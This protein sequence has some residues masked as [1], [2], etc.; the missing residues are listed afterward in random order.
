MVDYSFS[1]EAQCPSILG[2]KKETTLC[3]ISMEI[4]FADIPSS[5]MVH[6]YAIPQ[7]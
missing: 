3:C 1:P 6:T 2:A 5:S 4:A 7:L